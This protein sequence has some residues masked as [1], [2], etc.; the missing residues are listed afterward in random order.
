M[1]WSWLRVCFVSW[2]RR[3]A[4]RAARWW[5]EQLDFIEQDWE[6]AG[7]LWNSIE[8][9][10]NADSMN[11]EEFLAIFEQ[12]HAFRRATVPH[13]SGQGRVRFGRRGAA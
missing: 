3:R 12:H 1:F 8:V 7:V 6:A 4:Q 2:R 11:C 13:R 10:I 9:W 5:I